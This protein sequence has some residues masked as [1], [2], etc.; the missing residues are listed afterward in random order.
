MGKEGALLVLRESDARREWPLGDELLIGRD[1][2]A[3]VRLPD[4]QVSRHHARIRRT[5]GGYEVDDLGSKNGTW[6]NGRPVAGPTPLNDGDELSI[7]ARYKLYF[8]DA[9]ATAPV[10]FDPRGLRIEPDT[11]AVIVN[12]QTLDPP[13]SVLQLEL[14]AA[15]LES[16][17]AVVGR[18][19]LAERIWPYADGAGI[20]D[21]A[22]DA[23]VK[24]LR[25][26]L[27]EVDPDHGY[28]VTV[29]GYGYRLSQ[30]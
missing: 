29:R 27:A 20:T 14:L 10:T 11:R 25:Q 12:G 26:R 24:R 18:N 6:L 8:V 3:A 1:P 2:A 19:A 13:L 22:L 5:A 21:D 7:A 30:P 16:G 23:L 28:I 15:L 4:R 9:E 17:G